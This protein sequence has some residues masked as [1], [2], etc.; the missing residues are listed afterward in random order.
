MEQTRLEIAKW[1]RNVPEDELVVGDAKNVY[2]PEANRWVD[3]V[4]VSVAL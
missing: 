2:V 1:F 4:H 3:L